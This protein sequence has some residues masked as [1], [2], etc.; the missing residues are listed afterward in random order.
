VVGDLLKLRDGAGERTLDPPQSR[1]RIQHL[2]DAYLFNIEV[3]PS[4]DGD[5]VSW[6]EW[7]TPRSGWSAEERARSGTPSA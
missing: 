6:V 2:N 7:L 3:H 1:V 4:T 5:V